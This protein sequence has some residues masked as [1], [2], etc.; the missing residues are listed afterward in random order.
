MDQRRSKHT[1]ISRISCKKNGCLKNVSVIVTSAKEGV[2]RENMAQDQPQKLNNLKIYEIAQIE[3][4]C[5]KII[6]NNFMCHL[7]LSFHN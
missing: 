3:S 1:S 4:I 7:Q 6:N 5:V 2:P